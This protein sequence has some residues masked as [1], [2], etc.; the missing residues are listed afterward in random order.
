MHVCR[1]SEGKGLF[2]FRDRRLGPSP[3]GEQEDE[4]KYSEYLEQL[5]LLKIIDDF[6]QSHQGDGVVKSSPATNE[7]MRA[8]AEE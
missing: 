7:T 1:E 8:R 2:R 5:S 6:V 3:N 4:K